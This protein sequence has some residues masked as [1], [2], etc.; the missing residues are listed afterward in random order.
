MLQR[1]ALEEPDL[2]GV[3]EARHLEGHGRA[4]GLLAELRAAPVSDGYLLRT[5]TV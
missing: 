2:Q 1:A 5:L 3:D 4:Q